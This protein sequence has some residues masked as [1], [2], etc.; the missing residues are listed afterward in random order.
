MH[1]N[2]F[3]QFISTIKRYSHTFAIQSIK[4]LSNTIN[5]RNSEPR[6]KT[7]EN[8]IKDKVLISNF[9]ITRSAMTGDNGEPIG[10]L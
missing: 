9:R 3:S 6:R 7:A 5:E 2:E 4:L 8:R 10:V 1:P